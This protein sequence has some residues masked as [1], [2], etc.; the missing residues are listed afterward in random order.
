MTPTSQIIAR[1]I[2]RSRAFYAAAFRPL[3]L[4]VVD[5]G[6]GF[7]LA[8]DDAPVIRVTEGRWGLDDDTGNPETRP[9]LIGVEAPDRASARAVLFAAIQ[10]GGYAGVSGTD[11]R[12]IR[13]IDPDGNCIE[14]SC[15]N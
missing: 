13:V 15:R 11:R 2:H 1:D 7:A 4:S 5:A 9:A 14:C 6:D 10:A 3:G 12:R 8:G